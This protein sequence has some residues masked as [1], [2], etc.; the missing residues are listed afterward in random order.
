MGCCCYN[1]VGHPYAQRQSQPTGVVIHFTCIVLPGPP[2]CTAALI[3]CA[4]ISAGDL[5][6]CT[7]VPIPYLRSVWVCTG[8]GLTYSTFEYANMIIDSTA[9]T[10]TSV[11]FTV[12]N[13]GSTRAAEVAQLYIGKSC[14]LFA[15]LALLVIVVLGCWEG[16]WDS[17]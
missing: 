11:T 14:I 8:H 4:Y 16:S 17:V 3:Q 1:G 6:Q 9:G 12:T 10:N 7:V 5:K 15:K 13:T 2:E